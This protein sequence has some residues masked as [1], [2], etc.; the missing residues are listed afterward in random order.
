MMKRMNNISIAMNS[1]SKNNNITC[2]RI[3]YVIRVD[4]SVRN[5]VSPEEPCRPPGVF[6]VPC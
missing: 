2:S 1:V 5:L 4:V 6:L 3:N